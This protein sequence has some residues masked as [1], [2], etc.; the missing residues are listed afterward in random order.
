[1]TMIK[2]TY[3]SSPNKTVYYS[4]FVEKLQNLLHKNK[5]PAKI[6]LDRQTRNLLPKRRNC[7]A[8]RKMIWGTF[9]FDLSYFTIHLFSVR[10]NI[11]LSNLTFDLLLVCPPAFEVSKEFLRMTLFN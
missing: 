1:M 6:D 8:L 10:I 3:I 5:N 11:I 9:T 2:N 7:R 4:Y